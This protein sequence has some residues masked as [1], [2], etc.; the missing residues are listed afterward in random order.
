MFIASGPVA[1][2]VAKHPTT[3]MLAL[4]FLLLIGVSL[5]AD[6]A[7]F[8]IEKGYIYAAMGFSVLVEAFNIVSK[9]RR[10]ARAASAGHPVSATKREAAATVPDSAVAEAVAPAKPKRRST[11]AARAQSRP[12]SA[13]R[14]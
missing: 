7:G 14:K 6:G 11:P 10:L 2:F 8:H 1:S 13:P 3:K 5:V 4:A 9:Q 12:K